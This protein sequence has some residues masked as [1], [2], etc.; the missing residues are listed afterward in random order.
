MLRRVF[1]HINDGWHWSA[2]V[3]WLCALPLHDMLGLR[4]IM[5]RCLWGSV[6]TNSLTLWTVQLWASPEPSCCFDPRASSFNGGVPGGTGQVLARQHFPNENHLCEMFS[7]G[8][9]TVR[10]WAGLW[11]GLLLIA[12]LVVRFPATAQ[13]LR[14]SQC[15]IT[16]GGCVRKGIQ[17]KKIYAISNMCIM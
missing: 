7:E 16:W 3:V 9:F 8:L 17:H 4:T 12:R 11:S 15:Q 13:P 10:L 2:C 1:S 14:D 5:S 6:G